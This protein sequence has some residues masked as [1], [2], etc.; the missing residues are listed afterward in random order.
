MRWPWKQGKGIPADSDSDDMP[1]TTARTVQALPTSSKVRAPSNKLTGH[2]AF[3]L[4]VMHGLGALII[5]GGINFAIAYGM[6]ANQ[7]LVKNPIRLWRFPNTLSGDAAVTIFIQTVIT[8]TIEGISAN[9]D[10]RNGK[11]QAIG[12]IKEP[13]NRFLRWYFFLDA[14]QPAQGSK[15]SAK[16]WIVFLVM[17]LVRALLYAILL[18]FIFWPITVAALTAPGIS[19]YDGNGEYSYGRRWTPQVFK[20]LL[21]GLLGL[22]TTPPMTALWLLTVGWR[23][24]RAQALPTAIQPGVGQSVPVMTQTGHVAPT[25]S[26]TAPG[27]MAVGGGPIAPPISSI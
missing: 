10:L 13:R 27:E 7:N 23:L 17:Q 26:A 6:Y 19:D 9:G 16:Q 3:Y 4:F 25:G 5:S 20:L 14:E 2:Q 22:F 12:F 15:R 21:G 8:W 1:R 18:F 11:V 24:R